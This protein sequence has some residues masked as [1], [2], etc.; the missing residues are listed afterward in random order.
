MAGGLTV[1]LAL[2]L[3]PIGLLTV[4]SRRSIEPVPTQIDS[5]KD[6]TLQIPTYL[7]TFI[8]PFLF[9]TVDDPYNLAAYSVFML[10]VILM[11][12]RTE[13]SIINPGL[14]FI[15]FKIFDATTREGTSVMVISKTKPR[16][17]STIYASPISPQT[18]ILR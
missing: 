7:V 18:L 2:L 17:N 3:F 13:I 9:V 15:G 6:E 1:G 10:L 5:I 12:V 4:Y 14:L 8:L 16:V 11:L